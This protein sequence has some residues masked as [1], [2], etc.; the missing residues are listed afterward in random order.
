ME[1]FN[2]SYTGSVI[3]L[4]HFF[5]EDFLLPFKYIP[6][7]TIN[8]RII[9]VVHIPIALLSHDSSQK[10]SFNG[11]RFQDTL[12]ILSLPSLALISLIVQ[13]LVPPTFLYCILHIRGQSGFVYNFQI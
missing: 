3:V 10:I 6:G 8:N 12:K 11:R 13:A 9:I 7:P 5:K 2:L 1:S 4:L